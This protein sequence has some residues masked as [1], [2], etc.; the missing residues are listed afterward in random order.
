MNKDYNIIVIG[1]P[2]YISHYKKEGC[3]VA[4]ADSDLK[5][6]ELYKDKILNISL[7]NWGFSP[8][9]TQEQ[10]PQ[11][12]DDMELFDTMEETTETILPENN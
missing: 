9:E 8:I 3:Y 12:F 6:E 7:E 5:Q 2:E 4:A 1:R 11:I 10:L